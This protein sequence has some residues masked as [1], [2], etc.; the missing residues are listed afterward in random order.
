MESLN[1]D[2]YEAKE[3]MFYSAMISAWLNTKI[4][5]DKQLLGLYSQYKHLFKQ[6]P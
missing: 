4:E 2:D 1:Q 6:Y 5:R 3:K